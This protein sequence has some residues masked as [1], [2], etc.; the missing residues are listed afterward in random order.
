M[1]KLAGSLFFLA[2]QACAACLAV[3]VERT[4]GLVKHQWLSWSLDKLLL[5]ATPC[6]MSNS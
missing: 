6:N 1:K 3:G 2:F 5:Q 4:G